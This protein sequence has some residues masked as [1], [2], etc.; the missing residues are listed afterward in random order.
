[1]ILRCRTRPLDAT[2]FVLVVALSSNVSGGAEPA[3]E[4]SATQPA[5][6][7]VKLPG[8]VINCQERCVDLEGSI[9]LDEGMLELIACTKETKEHESTT[10]LH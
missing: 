7:N 3:T 2:F 6:K 5:R 10:P 4:E 8:L 1:V 9:C